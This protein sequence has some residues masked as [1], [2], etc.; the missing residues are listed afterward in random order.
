[1]HPVSDLQIEYSVLSR[2]PETEIFPVL[3]EL[4]IGVTAYGVL[5]RGLLSGSKPAG[6][7][8]WRAHLPRFT[9][10]NLTRNQRLITTLNTIAAEK[11]ATA[12]QLAIAWVLA[13]GE[14]IVPLIGARKRSQLDESLDAIGIQLTASDLA[15]IE[16]SIPRDAV[17]GTRY[18]EDQMRMLDSE[19]R[20]G[21]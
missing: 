5:S 4:G 15:Q 21:G 3:K 6:K 16:E 8:D 12:T 11:R 17:A 2:D 9:G 18:G 10:E 20:G 1:M 19:R 14:D 7:G 13:K